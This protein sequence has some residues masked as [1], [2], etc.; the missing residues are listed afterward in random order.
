MMDDHVEI[1]PSFPS[2][3]TN[4]EENPYLEGMEDPFG[5]SW[6]VI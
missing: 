2:T 4:P 6:D 1:P 5:S 3:K